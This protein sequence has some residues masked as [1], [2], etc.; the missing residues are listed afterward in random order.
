MDQLTHRKC[1]RMCL[2]S[3]TWHASFLWFLPLLCGVTKAY[4]YRTKLFKAT[5]PV[6]ASSYFYNLTGRYCQI[7]HEHA[8]EPLCSLNRPLGPV[9]QR[10]GSV[11][12]ALTNISMIRV[13][14]DK[15]CH[16]PLYSSTLHAGLQPVHG[17]LLAKGGGR[18]SRAI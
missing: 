11:M 15:V 9:G 18:Y 13:L 2:V 5:L 7:K 16:A 8:G 17:S 4:H 10:A 3:L 6:A 12:D 14:L 1:R